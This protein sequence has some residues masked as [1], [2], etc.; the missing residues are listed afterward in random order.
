MENEMNNQASISFLHF[1]DP[2]D[3]YVVGCTL[4]WLVYV[5]LQKEEQQVHQPVRAVACNV[6][7]DLV[8]PIK[9]AHSVGQI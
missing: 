7:R 8:L 4:C 6:F 1:A 3:L 9:G 2:R 5:L